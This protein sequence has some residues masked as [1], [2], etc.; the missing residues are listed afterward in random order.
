MEIATW[1]LN[2]ITVR[3][4]QL[5]EWLQESK[6]DVAGL[7]E[8]KCDTD[9]FPYDELKAAGYHVA[10]NG[11]PTYN[12][13]A[14]VSR[15][16]ITDVSYDLPGFEDDE[17][18]VIAGTIDGIRVINL[19]V[20]NGQD[21]KSDKYT[22]KLAWLKALTAYLKTELEAYESVVVLGDFNIAPTDD[23]VHN[24][25]AWKDRILCT[26]EE[27]AAFN[28]LLALGLTDGLR[29]FAEPK[30]QFTW[31][32]YR[33][34]GFDKNHGIR[35]DH[36]LLSPR[37]SARVMETKVYLN[38]RANERPSDHAPVSVVLR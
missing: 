2:S 27:R 36:L 29:I 6:I 16:E 25:K 37:V 30:V 23:D 10:V 13:V 35:I 21:P 18:R 14:L 7:Q 31:W 8:L 20:V 15:S 34:Q 12:G 38:V 24:P 33:S 26:D 11:Q 22:Y 28:E 3:L 4:P 32:D 1:N 17:K 9:K 5:L 19:Y